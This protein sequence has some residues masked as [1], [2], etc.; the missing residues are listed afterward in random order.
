E[1]NSV[2]RDLLK[3][4]SKLIDAN[5]MMHLKMIALEKLTGMQ[6]TRIEERK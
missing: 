5:L 6:L 3:A 2:Q 4:Q 1:L